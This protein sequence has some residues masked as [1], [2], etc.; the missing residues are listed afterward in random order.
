MNNSPQADPF[1]KHTFLRKF[2]FRSGKLSSRQVGWWSGLVVTLTGALALGWAT[3]QTAS[4]QQS[5]FNISTVAGSSGGSGLS[6]ELRNA[7]GVAVSPTNT[8][9]FYI[10]DTGNHVI[11]KVDT[12][13]NS[14]TIA[15][16]KLGEASTSA[17]DTNGDGGLATSATL[18][19]PNDV[20]TDQSGNLYISDTGNHR[21]RRVNVTD[22]TIQT[23]IGNGTAGDNGGSA[24]GPVLSEPRGL[25]LA[26]DSLYIADSASHRIYQVNEISGI[27]AN[28]NVTGIAGNGSR[29]ADG[30]GGLAT[31][32]SLDS[33]QD[34][35]LNGNTL[36]IADTNNHK[37]RKVTKNLQNISIIDTY[38]GTGVPGHSGD[39]GPALN[40][41]LNAPYGV[42]IGSQNTVYITDSGNNRIRVVDIDGF[43]TSVA[44]TG[45][46]GFNGDGTPGTNFALNAPSLAIFSNSSLVFLDTGNRR[47]RRL[48][49]TTLSTIVSDG[50]GG[51]SGDTGLATQAKL[52]GPAGIAVDSVGNWYIADGNNQVIRRVNKADGKIETIAGLPGMASVNPTD[53]NGDGGDAKLATFKSPSAVALDGAGNIYIADTG[54]RRIRKITKTD[55]KI[56][57]VM[58]QVGSTTFGATTLL[59]PTGVALD[60]LNNLYVADPAQHIVIGQNG[61]G[62]KTLLAGKA[63]TQGFGGDGGL[64]ENARLN[65]PTGLA[66]VGTTIYVADTNNHRIRRIDR[67]ND[68]YQISSIVPK[69]A[70]VVQIIPRPGYEGDGGLADFARLNAPTAVAADSAGTLF[71]MDRGNNRVRRV[72]GTTRIINTVVGNG[73]I[74]F[75]GD[76]GPALSAALGQP[77]H[78]AIIPNTNPIECWP[79]AN[80]ELNASSLLSE[81]GC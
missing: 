53:L 40:M 3:W 24:N 41:Q 38:A 25:L 59:Q 15:A 6:A 8:A 35:A 81:T 71:I 75:S 51:F 67:V 23:I 18:K 9:I 79:S 37:V 72:D 45:A 61:L 49:G 21:I 2:V 34:I 48:A 65:R 47:L 11:R 30:D 33:P 76:G 73:D 80:V 39:T 52:D 32:A 5:F 43:M 22:G 63:S 16:G 44:G 31:A 26:N 55:G 28:T 46:Q 29:G 58:G 7:R 36:Y 19:E 42:A 66:V 4:A 68:T 12:S 70:G 78:L 10:A 62:T 17:T 69:S 64:A 20:V 13:T 27:T 50:S 1:K 57:T 54:N 56:E 74:G 14:V 60:T 77:L